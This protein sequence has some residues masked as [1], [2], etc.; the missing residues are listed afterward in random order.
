MDLNKIIARAK[1]IL[2]SPKTEW[3]VIA[4]EPDTIPGLYAGYIAVLAA[5]PPI[6]G[7]LSTTLIG[8]SV[9]FLGG[10]FLVGWMEEIR[11]Y[12]ELLP[13]LLPACVLG[14]Q[15]ALRR[16]RTA[17]QRAWSGAAAA[18]TAEQRWRHAVSRRKCRAVGARHGV[19][20]SQTEPPPAPS[21]WTSR[22][23]VQY[24]NDA[25]PLRARRSRSSR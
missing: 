2:L 12:A 10:M 14:L 4:A 22:R 9:P 24:A 15:G 17:L 5:I 11:I 6:V 1:A 7:F 16:G 13:V 3:P 25:A 19:P 8:V 18:T 23:R 21:V 20:W